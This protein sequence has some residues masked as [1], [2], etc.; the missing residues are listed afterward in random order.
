M[1]DC[2]SPNHDARTLLVSMAVLHYTGMQSATAALQLRENPFD[3]SRKRVEVAGE[4]GVLAIRM[5]R[6]HFA[7]DAEARAITLE[8]VASGYS[9]EELADL[10]DDP[11]GDKSIHLRFVAEFSQT[12][13]APPPGDAQNSLT[14]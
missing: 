2:P 3:G 14:Q 4:A 13:D 1:I 6:I 12:P 5:F 11:Y 8:A 10:A 7:I 9:P